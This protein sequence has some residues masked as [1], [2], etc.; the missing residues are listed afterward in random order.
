[1]IIES[2]QISDL[3][4]IATLQPM[5][6]PDIVPDIEYYIHSP[7]CR[8]VKVVKNGVIAGIGANIF[9][10]GTC[11]LAHI[12]VNESYRNKG[13]GTAI[14]A[15]L[16]NYAKYEGYDTQMLIATELGEPVYKK[17]GFKKV[18]DYLFF[19]RTEPS[20]IETKSERIIPYSAQYKNALLE[21]DRYVTGENRI[22]ILEKHLTSSY[23]IANQN[24]IYA[25]YIPSLG[26]GPIIAQ[27]KEAGIE[28]MQ[29][30]YA[31]VDKA[32][33]PAENATGI[34]FLLA[35]GFVQVSKCSRMLYGK[36]IPCHPE[37]IY[38]RIRGNVG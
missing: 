6:W 11:W 15:N 37:M 35:N 26:E 17:S 12:I 3:S 4:E 27:D 21:L 8:A 10:E 29:Y 9:F 38:S 28:L 24:E 14:V 34:E 20:H 30:K 25:F 31:T 32:V 7:F 36:E 16:M 1:M 5:D 23:L 13:I 18:T 22:N 2:I 19:K 33:L